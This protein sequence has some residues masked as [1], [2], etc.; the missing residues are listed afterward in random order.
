MPQSALCML[1]LCVTLFNCLR[2]TTWSKWT[3]GASDETVESWM[4]PSFF[5][6]E[7]ARKEGASKCNVVVG[8]EFKKSMTIFIHFTHA[9]RAVRANLLIVFRSNPSV[10]PFSPACA[11]FLAEFCNP[12]TCQAIELESCSNPLRIQQVL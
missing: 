4:H 5:G 6:V 1:R 9:M 8:A 3:T 2:R 10:N 12:I 7:G 11:T